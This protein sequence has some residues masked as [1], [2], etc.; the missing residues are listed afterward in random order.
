MATIACRRVECWGELVV[1]RKLRSFPTWEDAE[2]A[3]VRLTVKVDARVL[4]AYYLS[5]AMP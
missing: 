4:G 5:F 1:G 3:G 2:I